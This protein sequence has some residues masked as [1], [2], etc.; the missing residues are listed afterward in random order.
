MRR[1][2]YSSLQ[3]GSEASPRHGFRLCTWVHV[4][5]SA[6]GLSFKQQPQDEPPPGGVAYPKTDR[7]TFLETVPEDSE[8]QA[9]VRS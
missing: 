3:E 7:L 9:A 8:V 6:Q 2:G 4:C 5:A 1:T